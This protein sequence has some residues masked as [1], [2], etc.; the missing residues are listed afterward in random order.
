[1]LAIHR[2][3]FTQVD[4]VEELARRS[5]SE[6]WDGLWLSDSQNLQSDALISLGLAARCT[7]RLTLSTAAT[8]LETRHP[9]VTACAIATVDQVSGGRAALGLGR[10]DTALTK[11]GLKPRP[12]EAFRRGI[13]QLQ[14]FLRGE[15]VE[16]PTGPSRI[17]WLRDR[18]KVPLNLFA[19][20]PRALTLG[21][22]LA[23][24][25]T[26][27]VGASPEWARWGVERVR[28]VSP[29]VQVGLVVLLGLGRAGRELVRGNVTIFAQFAGAAARVPG[30]LD[31]QDAAVLER[32]RAAYREG[33]AP[34]PV[35]DDFID[36]FAV[37]GDPDHC[38]ARVRALAGLGLSHLLVVGPWKTAEPAAIAEHDACVPE[39]L[40]QIGR[41]TILR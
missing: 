7:S 21:A 37:V 6:G 16:L 17:E 36:R 31:E 41:T 2:F 11:L 32:A 24:Q 30:L 39:F 38:L 1:M 18:R 19:S 23:E 40:R 15:E 34:L 33:S 29:D 10:G 25:V 26:L 4:Q 35:P 20:G 5:E 22:E 13:V 3:A 9:A 27:A 14:G 28:A 8:N 12:F